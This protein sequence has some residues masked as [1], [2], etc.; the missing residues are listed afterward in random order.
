MV[1][2]DNIIVIGNDITRIAHLEKHLSN[3]F[4]TK[5]LGYLKY[6][7]DIEVAQSKGVII[8]QRKYVG[9][10]KPDRLQAHW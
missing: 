4:P 2:V 8:S 3:H 7:L 10:D 6:F 9:G 5:D 1:Y